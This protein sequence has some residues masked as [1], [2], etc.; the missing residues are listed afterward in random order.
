MS[1]RIR[2]RA[3]WLV[4]LAAV[5][6][7]ASGVASPRAAA[8][9]RP[10]V[11]GLRP[12]SGPTTG[13]NTV[14]IRGRAFTSFRR[15]VVV[16]VTFGKKAATNIHICT[17]SL[18]TVTAPA[19]QGTLQVFVTTKSGVSAAAS[20]KRGRYT[21]KAISA[22]PVVTGVSPSA[23]PL[24]GGAGV[25]ITGTGFTP[26]S[27]VDFPGV[28][29][30]ATVVGVGGAGTQIVVTSPACAGAGAT[31]D[32]TVTTAGGTSATSSAD[33]YTYD[34]VPTVTAVTPD[35]GPRGG[36]AG[37]T[38]TGTGFTSDSVVDFAGV[39]VPATV[40]S[41]DGAGTQIV[42]TTPACAGG[43]VTGDV[44]VTTPRRHESHVIGRPVY[45]QL[46]A[47]LCPARAGAGRRR[48]GPWRRR[49]GPRPSPPDE[50]S[51]AAPCTVGCIDTL[52]PRRP[53]HDGVDLSTVRD[54]ADRDHRPYVLE[55]GCADR[56]QHV[57]ALLTRKV[58]PRQA[59]VVSTADLPD[60]PAA[61]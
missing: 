36:G 50:A 33:Q 26:D 24:A 47:S 54:A 6:V 48:R 58:F 35:N 13:G 40:D 34:P 42:V 43:G 7:L 16:R 1:K 14:A 59:W 12:V 57:H 29:V 41:V 4:G 61:G 10:V 22:E 21:Y 27:T 52:D 49:R 28:P 9:G 60:L 2:K 37:V 31:G 17:H 18:L 25:T 3:W 45:F 23:G 51:N 38:I 11:T 56:D 46:V 55:D 8:C 30:A 19:G 53:Q 15:S 32:V 20:K 5:V 44:T 39:S